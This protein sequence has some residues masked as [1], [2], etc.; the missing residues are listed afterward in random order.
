MKNF[1]TILAAA[2]LL[3]AT[4][5]FASGGDN[6]STKV[7]AAFLNNFGKAEQVSWTEKSDFYF[8]HFNLN[9][10]ASEAAYTADGELLGTSRKIDA[11]QLPL[12]LTLELSKR[13]LGYAVSAEV[14]ELNFEGSTRYYITVQN[15]TQVVDLKGNGNG[16]LDVVKKSKKVGES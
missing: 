16:E 7:K 9:G 12:A 8:A 5:S 13:Y 11:S 2:A 1:K 10:I 3:I 6:V 14:T 4:S 15:N